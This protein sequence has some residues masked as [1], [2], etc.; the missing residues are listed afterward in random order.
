MIVA[1]RNNLHVANLTQSLKKKKSCF[2]LSKYE[3]WIFTCKRHFVNVFFV[4]VCANITSSFG[5]N[6]SIK[7]PHKLL[8]EDLCE[9]S[10]SILQS[11]NCWYHVFSG[12]KSIGA[13]CINDYMT[14]YIHHLCTQSDVLLK[15]NVDHHTQYTV[16]RITVSTILQNKWA[17]WE[18]QANWLTKEKR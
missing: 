13:L 11:Q 15:E 17:A 6:K 18:R 5:G 12:L 8:C 16:S 3:G 14:V 9:Q 4:R 7:V 1:A 2:W 10:N